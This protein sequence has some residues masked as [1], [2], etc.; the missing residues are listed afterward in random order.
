MRINR[1]YTECLFMAALIH[2]IKS[3]KVYVQPPSVEAEEVK[4]GC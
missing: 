3:Y 4:C 1:L 2:E